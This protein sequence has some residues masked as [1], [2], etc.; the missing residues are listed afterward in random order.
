MS[1]SFACDFCSRKYRV[2]DE[3][4]GRKVKCKECGAELTIPRPDPVFS[5]KPAPSPPRDL[6]G[7]DDEVGAPM[8]PPRRPG[9]SAEAPPRAEAR[10]RKRASR[11]VEDN[12]R[13]RQAGTTLMV[14]GGLSFVLPYVGLQIKGLHL[15][16]PEAQAVGGAVMLVLGL[17]F[18]VASAAGFLQALVAGAIGAAALMLLVGVF[19]KGVNAP[20]AVAAAPRPDAAVGQ[21]QR[22]GDTPPPVAAPPAPPAAPAIGRPEAPAIHI[23][24]SNGRARPRLTPIGTPGMGVTFSADYQMDG[25]RPFG[26]VHYHTVVTSSRGRARDAFTFL[27][28]S[29]TI[30]GSVPT[31]SQSDG[32]F[33]MHIEADVVEPGVLGQR[34]YT[35]S[36]SLPLPWSDPPPPQNSPPGFGPP[37]MGPNGGMPG[38]PGYRPPGMPAPPRFGRG[39]RF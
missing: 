14:L 3:L 37:G 16:P 17:F 29:G 2:G 39:R 31:F 11:P 9:A 27:H 4:S 6:Y 30:G 23:T 33:E 36:N 22:Q 24:L 38:Q 32:P 10:R 19:L 21:P 35:V 25:H 18:L 26:V 1:I 15:M 7:L 5:A 20:Q 13:L 34:S 28:N 8:P 12:P